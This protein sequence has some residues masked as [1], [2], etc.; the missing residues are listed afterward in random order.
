M[1]TFLLGFAEDSVTV[2]EGHQTD[3]IIADDILWVF[4][5]VVSAEKMIRSC[6][7]KL[8]KLVTQNNIQDLC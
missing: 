1:P 6:C 4:E 3:V 7:K 2:G 8:A 5:A